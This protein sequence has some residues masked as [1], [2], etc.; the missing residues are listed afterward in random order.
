MEK[1]LVIVICEKFPLKCPSENNG[2]E[3]KY[4]KSKEDIVRFNIYML[5][6]LFR[7]YFLI[8]VFIDRHGQN[9]WSKNRTFFGISRIDKM[10]IIRNKNS[11]EKPIVRKK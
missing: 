6:F 4:D 3:E 10:Q 9:T 11:Y 2:E 5:M 8:L 1:L 7:L